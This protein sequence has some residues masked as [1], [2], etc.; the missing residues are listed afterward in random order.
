M[1][2]SMK[3]HPDERPEFI[4]FPLPGQLPWISLD[5]IP[6]ANVCSSPLT[7]WVNPFDLHIFDLYA[8]I[9]FNLCGLIDPFDLQAYYL[10][11]TRAL[12]F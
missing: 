11:P 1:E 7:I 12:F 9:L 6:S 4:P 5:S 2:V 3:Y 8:L 10:R